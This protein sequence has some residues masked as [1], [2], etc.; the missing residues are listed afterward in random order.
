MAGIGLTSAAGS[1]GGVNAAGTL[2]A[3]VQANNGGESFSSVLNN[4]LEGE[5][6]LSRTSNYDTLQ[7]LSG[8]TDSLATLMASAK[9]S[10]IAVDLTVAVRNKAMD[11]YK[12]IMN[13]QV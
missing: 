1:I 4:A 10:E 12:E 13:M 11:A 6:N 2:K 7:L 3:G 5:E 9:K 8:N